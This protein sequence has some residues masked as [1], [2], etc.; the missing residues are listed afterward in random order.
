MVNWFSRTG[1]RAEVPRLRP[2]S[3]TEPATKVDLAEL[4]PDLLTF[5]GKAAYLQL[6]IFEN[7]GRA[8]A[9]APT[10]EAKEVLSRVA[11]LSLA[12]HHGLTAEIRRHGEEPGAVMEPFTRSIDDF[13]RVTQGGDWFEELLACHITAGFLDDFFVHLAAGLPTDYAGRVTTVL[14]ADSGAELL[15]DE[16]RREIEADDKLDSRLAMWG[17]RLVGDTMLVARATLAPSANSV[18]DEARI[19]PV[20]TELIAAHTRRMDGL[21]LTA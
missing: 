2:R 6:T 18:S 21:G 17:R 10:T 19:E 12:K 16:L 15:A 4:T 9:V 8:M 13:Q 14:R 7:L 11:A 5:L 20:F 3:E 1:K